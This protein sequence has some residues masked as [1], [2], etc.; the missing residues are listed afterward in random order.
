MF[1]SGRIQ[2]FQPSTDFFEVLVVF[3][4]LGDMLYFLLH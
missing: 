2:L 3:I 4:R 1:C